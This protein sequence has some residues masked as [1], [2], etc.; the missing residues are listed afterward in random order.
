[1]PILTTKAVDLQWLTFSAGDSRAI[2]WVQYGQPCMGGQ[3]QGLMPEGV[4][5]TSYM[6]SSIMLKQQALTLRVVYQQP[7]LH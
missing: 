7:L 6:H 3:V 5:R 4:L 1:M 2:L